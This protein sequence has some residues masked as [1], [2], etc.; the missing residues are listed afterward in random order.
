MDNQPQPLPDPSPHSESS[1]APESPTEKPLYPFLHEVGWN[2]VD[3]KSHLE[4]RNFD[5]VTRLAVDTDISNGI[6]YEFRQCAAKFN[7]L[8][9]EFFEFL[10][11]VLPETIVTTFLHHDDQK[12]LMGIRVFKLFLN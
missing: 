1:P 3:E 9:R 7:F 2:V 11:C 10:K 8:D 4:A 6:M 12:K 5:Q